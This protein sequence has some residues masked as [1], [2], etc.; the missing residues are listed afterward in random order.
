MRDWNRPGN[1]KEVLALVN[2]I[3]NENSALHHL[4]NICFLPADS[5]DILF[6]VK[7][8][9]DRSNVILVAVNLDPFQ[10]HECTVTVPPEEIG[11]AP[12][13][14][15]QVTDLLTGAIYT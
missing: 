15:Y 3:G 13:Q 4:T 8:S 12:G 5:D 10:W 1:I 11:V 2:R 9:L 6:Y 14:T 7:A